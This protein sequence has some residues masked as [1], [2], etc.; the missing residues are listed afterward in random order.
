MPTIVPIPGELILMWKRSEAKPRFCGVF[1]MHLIA[2]SHL[3]IPA[4]LLSAVQ[5]MNP[6]WAQ[7]S[8]LHYPAGSDITFQWNYS[9]PS[10][11]SCSFSC[12]GGGGAGQVTKLTIYL[13]TIPVGSMQTP[14]MLYEFSTREIPSGNGFVVTSGLSTLSC[15]VNGMTIDYSGPTKSPSSKETVRAK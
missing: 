3:R 13:G 4:A 11:A 8:E 1:Q 10:R 5:L 6:L 15:Q 7:E 12:P 9:C 2:L 14:A